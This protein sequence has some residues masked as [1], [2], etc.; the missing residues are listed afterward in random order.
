[1]TMDGGITVGQLKTFRLRLKISLLEV[2]AESGLPES[3]LAQI[4]SGEV[5]ASAADLGRIERTLK[6]IEKE[7][8]QPDDA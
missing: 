8:T 2:A 1:M 5:L 3:Y 6:F 7:N 4:E